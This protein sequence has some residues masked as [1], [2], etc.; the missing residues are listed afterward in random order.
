MLTPS[1]KKKHLY[2][3]L[4]ELYFLKPTSIKPKVPLRSQKNPGTLGKKGRRPPC[5]QNRMCKYKPAAP[6]GLLMETS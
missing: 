2:F 5:F 6:E 4:L 1:D 3:V